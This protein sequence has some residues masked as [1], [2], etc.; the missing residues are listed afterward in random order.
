[1]K[2]GNRSK[3]EIPVH[4]ITVTASGKKKMLYG[5]INGYGKE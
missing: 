2:L 4:I 1:M 3:K 5:H